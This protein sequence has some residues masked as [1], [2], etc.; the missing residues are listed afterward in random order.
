MLH[1]ADPRDLDVFHAQADLARQHQPL[2]FRAPP[3]D[4]A[5]PKTGAR[6]EASA[7][8]REMSGDAIGIMEGAYFVSRKDCLDWLNGL[9]GLNYTKVEQVCN[10]AAFCQIMDAIFPG[11][12]PLHKVNFGAKLQ[13]EVSEE[14]ADYFFQKKARLFF[15][16]KNLVCLFCD[17]CM[18]PQMI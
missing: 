1:I 8:T 7:H 18:R 9:L 5:R 14:E 16:R 11:K 15:S 2:H 17:T 13:Y 4:H 6:S 12:V 3:W 10:G